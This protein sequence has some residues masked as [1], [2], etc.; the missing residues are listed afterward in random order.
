MLIRSM[1]SKQYD[2]IYISH[3]DLLRVFERALRRA[4]I[5]TEFSQ[6][7]NP[8]PKITFAQALTL[9]TESQSEYIDVII[10]DNIS[11]DEF[12]DRLNKVLPQGIEILKSKEMDLKSEALMSIV[13]NAR[14]AIEIKSKNSFEDIQ[15]SIAVLL[16]EEEIFIEK[17]SKKKKLQ[18]IDIRPLIFDAQIFKLKDDYFA[19]N[20]LLGCGSAGNLKP[21]IFIKILEEKLENSLDIK[22]V[23]RLA[24][25]RL[26]EDKMVD[27]FS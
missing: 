11:T 15:N 2:M 1:F 5:Q 20:L 13:S 26:K 18:K 27:L 16:K 8:R 12:K 7:F 10:A 14:Y 19:L 21:E 25:Y 24:L 3:L 4:K 22:N 9:G 23:L 17:L 6:G